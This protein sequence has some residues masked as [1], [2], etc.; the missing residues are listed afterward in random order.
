MHSSTFKT[1]KERKEKQNRNLYFNKNKSSEMSD[2]LFVQQL[3][4]LFVINVNSEVLNK[5]QKQN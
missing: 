3:E 4:F 2:C 5:S 1:Y